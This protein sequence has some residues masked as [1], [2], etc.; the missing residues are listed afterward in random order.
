MTLISFLKEIINYNHGNEQVMQGGAVVEDR[1]VRL[2]SQYRIFPSG[3]ETTN[4]VNDG[5]LPDTVIED[6]KN[7]Y[8]F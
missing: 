8:L 7:V 4:I 1:R 6:K 2:I 3:E 5:M